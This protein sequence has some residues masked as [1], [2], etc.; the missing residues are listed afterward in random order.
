[1]TKGTPRTTMSPLKASKP[2]RIACLLPSATEICLALGLADDIVGVTHECNVEAVGAAST[3]KGKSV[4]VLTKDGLNVTEQG[5]IHK[6]VSDQQQKQKSCSIEQNI[7]P[8]SLY[9]IVE[10]EWNKA[11]P[12]V[13]LTQD[14]CSVCAPSTEDV[15]NIMKKGKGEADDVTIVSLKPTSLEDVAQTF[16][17]VATA[18]GVPERGME[19]RAKFLGDLKQLNTSIENNRDKT[20]PKPS[21]LLLEWLDPPFDGGHW[22]PQMMNFACTRAA[23]PKEVNK[24]HPISWD[25]INDVDPDVLVIACCGFDLERNLRDARKSSRQLSNLSAFANNTIYAANGN[26]YFACPGPNLIG[27][28][29]ILA[30]C[31][32]QDQPAVLLAIDELASSSVSISESHS[33]WQRVNFEQGNIDDMEDIGGRD[34]SFLHDRACAAGELKYVD[35]DTGYTVMTELAHKKRGACCGSGCRHCPF[36]HENVKDKSS[37]IQQPALLYKG[38]SELFSITFHDKI[39]ILFFSG[40]KIHF[41]PCEH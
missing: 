36:N 32:Y 1:M 20:R 13:I 8:E 10:F 37:H 14:L 7:L 3:H 19:L 6:A 18:C 41:S 31:A 5:D 29:A 16:V 39:K 21:L 38:E 2:F 24:S 34:F 40:G 15:K 4:L 28:T 23:M 27:G 9:P 12:T 26:A 35:P 25:S 17:T 11:A 22:I 30:R 33:G